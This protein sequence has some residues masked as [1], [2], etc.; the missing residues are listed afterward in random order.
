M[1]KIILMPPVF[2]WKGLNS[3]QE[4]YIRSEDWRAWFKCGMIYMLCMLQK[5]H[6]IPYS[7]VGS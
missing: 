1:Q 2:A 4:E 6:A 5:L 7:V 3:S